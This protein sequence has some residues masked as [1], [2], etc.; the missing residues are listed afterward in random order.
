MGPKEGGGI[1]YFKVAYTET[2]LK[3]FPLELLLNEGRIRSSNGNV[4]CIG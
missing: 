3:K 4:L 1:Y 2:I